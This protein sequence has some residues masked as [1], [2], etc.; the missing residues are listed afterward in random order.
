MGNHDI[1]VGDCIG[2]CP[3]QTKKHTKSYFIN[4]DYIVNFKTLSRKLK[5]TAVT[6]SVKLT[7]LTK[8]L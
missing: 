4:I 5:K 6:T 2:K 7:G 3:G 1:K 8:W